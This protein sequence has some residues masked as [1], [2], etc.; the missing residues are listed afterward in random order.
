MAKSKEEIKKEINDNLLKRIIEPIA[1]T[2]ELIQRTENM[3]YLIWRAA[4]ICYST[5]SISELEQ[6]WKE[7][8]DEKRTG[9]I[10]G[11][12][13]RGH[14]TTYS[15]TTFSY[16]IVCSRVVSHQIVRHQVGVTIDQESQRY[17]PYETG[18]RY[19]QP[20]GVDDNIFKKLMENA[21]D[22]Y[23]KLYKEYRLSGL[24]KRESAELA[25]YVL[26]SAISTR[27]ICTISLA[28]LIHL[29]NVRVR[30]DTGRPQGETQGVSKEMV[31]LAVEAEPWLKPAFEKKKK[32]AGLSEP[33]IQK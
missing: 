31:R 13:E 22:Q 17:V 5:K 24:G 1:P 32:V 21:H 26:P 27:M 25:R 16:V 29:N 12:I 15:H 19:I 3:K 8:P 28:A 18:F 6:E 2:V 11:L 14:R 9:L 20:E 30:G 10:S 7:T 23:M 4:R 33:I